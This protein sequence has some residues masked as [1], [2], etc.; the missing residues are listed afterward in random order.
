M[1]LLRLESELRGVVGSGVVTR[2]SHEGVHWNDDRRADGD[3]AIY[4][5]VEWRDLVDAHAQPHEVL[6]LETIRASIDPFPAGFYASGVR[7]PDESSQTLGEL[8]ASRRQFRLLLV[9]GDSHPRNRSDGYW[10]SNGPGVVIGRPATI[11][12][13]IFAIVAQPASTCLRSASVMRS[14]SSPS[15]AP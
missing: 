8:W 1:Y 12:M 14:N 6:S 9:A 3:T 15:G 11:D 4:V 13:Y 10:A 2:G 5:G 7:V